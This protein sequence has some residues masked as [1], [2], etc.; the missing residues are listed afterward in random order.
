MLAGFET[1]DAGPH[2]DRRRRHG[3]RAALSPAGQHDVPVLCALP[4][5][6]GGGECRLRPEAGGRAAAPSAR[7]AS[8][9]CSSWSSSRGC[10]ERKPHQLSGGQRQRVALARALVEG[11]EAAAAR[12]AAGRARPQAARGDPLRADAHPAARRHHLPRRDARP[13]RGDEHGVAHRRDERK[14][15]I[16]QVGTPQR[17]LRSA[18]EPLR[19]RLHRR[20]EPVRGPRRAART[21][22]LAVECAEAGGE[23]VAATQAPLPAAAAVAS[24]S[25]RRRSIFAQRAAECARNRL[26]GTVARHR[27]SRRGLDLEVEL[28]AARCC[29]STSANAARAASASPVRATRCALRLAARGASWCCRMSAARVRGLARLACW[30]CPMPGCCCSSWCRSL[31][32]ASR[33]ASPRRRSAIPPYTPLLAHG[34][35][36]SAPGARSTNY[37]L[38]PR[39]TASTAS[40]YLNSLEFAAVCDVA[41]PADRLSDGLCHGARAARWRTRLLLLVILPFWTSFLIRVYAWIGLLKDNGLHQ[42]RAAWRWASIHAAAGASH[43]TTSRSR[44]ASSIPT[45]RS[46]SCRSTPTWRSSTG[47]ARGRGR[48]RLPAVAGLLRASPCRC[49]CRASSP[50]CAAGL[51]PGGAANSSFPTC[52]GGPNTLMIGK[53]LW[54][55]FFPNRDWPMASAVAI[56]L[57]VLLVAPMLL[58]QRAGAP[59]GGGVMTGRAVSSPSV[60]ALGLAFL[61]VPIALVVVYSFNASRLVTVWAGFSHTLVRGARRTTRRCS[62]RPGSASSSLLSSAI[63]RAGARHAG[64][65]SRLPASRASAA[66]PCSPAWSSRRWSCPKSSPALSLLLLFVA[67]EQAVGWPRGAAF[68]TLVIAHVSFTLA[69]VAVIVAGAARR[70]RPRARGGGARSRRSARQGLLCHHPAADRAG[71]GGRLAAR[72]HAHRS[73]IW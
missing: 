13:G 15:A 50:G 34:P 71:A 56:A 16:V 9:R 2:P 55:E 30:R 21:A 39:A 11:A 19:R 70:F 46:W 51:H 23:L 41:L 63:A 60:L 7:R 64:R 20:G 37:A 1:P 69:Y 33:S 12:R 48:S 54:D 59:A 6:D 73:T 22:V 29:A 61:Y 14:A 47:A 65:L 31:I 38:P 52:S 4:A 72:L 5:Y 53:V 57:L 66:G 25:A 26:A 10:A 8:R 44:S 28:P 40:A 45:C 27:L 3:R 24:R 42:Q 58:L 62:A 32:V 36:A 17:D 43:T 49:R 68:S 35:T 67:L 18:R